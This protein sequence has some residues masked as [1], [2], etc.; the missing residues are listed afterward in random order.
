VVLVTS[1]DSLLPNHPPSVRVPAVQMGGAAKFED[2]KRPKP[3]I[4]QDTCTAGP[5]GAL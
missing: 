1:Q 5:E 4:V 2:A 3:W